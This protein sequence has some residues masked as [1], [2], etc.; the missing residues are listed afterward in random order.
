MEL[1]LVGIVAGLIIGL[2]P[3]GRGASRFRNILVGI[4]GAI[5]G[6]FLYKQFLT[7]V[8]RL[9]LPTL[10]LDLNQVVIAL[11]GGF[12]FLFLISLVNRGK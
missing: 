7:G 11:L 8:L 12:L 10:E 3:G 4:V 5:L 2:F 9:G 6:S 1:L